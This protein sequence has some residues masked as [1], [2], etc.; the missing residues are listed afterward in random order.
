[1]NK[2]I[3]VIFYL[4]ILIS[5][6]DE[7]ELGSSQNRKKVPENSSNFDLDCRR[8][9]SIKFDSFQKQNLKLK[10]LSELEKMNHQNEL[11]IHSENLKL[12]IIE[13]IENQFEIRCINEDCLFER[14]KL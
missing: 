11:L 8:L 5:C 4:F 12:K 2:L 1:M 9:E 3:L 14:K 10:V 7:K 13:C 6:S